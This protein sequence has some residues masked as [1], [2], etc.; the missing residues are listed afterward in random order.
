[1]VLRGYLF[2]TVNGIKERKILNSFNALVIRK[3]NEALKLVSKPNHS[4]DNKYDADNFLNGS[5]TV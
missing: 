2:A 5:R 3:S 1:M 4:A